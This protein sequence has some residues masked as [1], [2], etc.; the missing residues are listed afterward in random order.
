MFFWNS[1][2]PDYFFTE[3]GKPIYRFSK[4]IFNKKYNHIYGHTI[5]HAYQMVVNKFGNFTGYFPH[6]GID[7][8]RKSYIEEC[9]ENFKKEF[10][11]TVH[12]KFRSFDDVQRAIFSYYAISQNR[13]AAIIPNKFFS[14]FGY[15]KDSGFVECN[16]RN[17]LKI[18]KID[19]PL[20]CING[21]RKT[22]KED[23]KLMVEI[24]EN[25]FHEKTEFEK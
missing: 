1:I 25:K 13:A 17:L 20:I 6:H 5:K 12:H 24:L 3:E 22:T 2:S 10:D 16:K 8:Y 23:I 19:S 14:Y 21:N 9:I 15:T 11:Q 7:P 4:R 18:N